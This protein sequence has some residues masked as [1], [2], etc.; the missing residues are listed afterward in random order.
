MKPEYMKPARI[1][2]A[3]VVLV[4]LFVAL[5]QNGGALSSFFQ[6]PDAPLPD[7]TVLAR[8]NDYVGQAISLLRTGTFNYGRINSYIGLTRRGPA[9][10][11][12]LA[13]FFMVFGEY[14]GIVFLANAFFFILALF[15]LWRISLKLL[16]GDWWPLLPPALLGMW[17]GSVSYIWI[18]NNET[19]TLFIITF[20][21]WS[22]YRWTETYRPRWL[23]MGALLAA[24]LAFAKPIAFY[25]PF[26]IAVL[27]FLIARPSMS[28]KNNFVYLGI[29]FAFYASIVG[30]WSFRN[31]YVLDS[32]QLG[33]GGHSIL[34]RASQV[35]FSTPQIISAGL[36]FAVGDYIGK[37]VYAGYPADGKPIS[38]DPAI[39]K[40]WYIKFLGK[41]VSRVARDKEFY[42]EAFAKIKQHPFKFVATSVLG[43]AR[44]NGPINHRGQEIMR[45]FLDSHGDFSPFVKIAVIIVIRLAWLGALALAAIGI[46]ARRR[47]WRLWGLPFL[48]ILYFN[49]M[50]AFF[51][52]AEARYILPVM[53]FYFLFLTEGVRLLYGKIVRSEISRS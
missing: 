35:D 48:L 12:A 37:R 8:D 9:Y 4:A 36:S 17:P 33:D 29:F 43:I 53:P 38:W 27:M 30:L 40:R 52:H 31:A 7:S 44:L 10:S 46:L 22:A 34:R 25:L 3:Y 24:L 45:L 42:P 6:S 51:T 1:L 2:F 15:F 50:Y 49:G 11:M 28:W 16:P 41:D 23:L 21:V 26:A 14:I 47:Q 13:S 5:S 20:F 18:F 19:W 32:W 39:D